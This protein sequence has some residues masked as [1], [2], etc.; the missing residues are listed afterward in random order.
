MN[1]EQT[2]YHAFLNIISTEIKNQ[3][4]TVKILNHYGR[5]AKSFCS[6]CMSDL[7]VIVHRFLFGLNL[8]SSIEAFFKDI[9][10]KF[11]F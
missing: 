3:F 10:F 7:D 11:I 2:F 8:P 4:V 9:L 1:N 6:R 5:F